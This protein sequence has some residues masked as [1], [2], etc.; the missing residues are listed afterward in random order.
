M[1][2]KYTFKAQNQEF[3]GYV[4]L[5]QVAHAD[6]IKRDFPDETSETGVTTKEGCV[7]TFNWQVQKQI[8]EPNYAVPTKAQRVSGQLPPVQSW[9]NTIMWVNYTVVIEKPEEV[10]QLKSYY[11]KLVQ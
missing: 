7:L 6:F 10:E 4:N 5:D 1:I 9:K 2:F 11:E 3:P 8:P